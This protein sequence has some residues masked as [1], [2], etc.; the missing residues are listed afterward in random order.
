MNKTQGKIQVWVDKMGFDRVV[1]FC[2]KEVR[3]ATK[4][5]T[6]CECLDFVEVTHRNRVYPVMSGFYIGKCHSN[7]CILF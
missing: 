4:T 6:K 7:R 3:Q 5:Y 2:R 1:R